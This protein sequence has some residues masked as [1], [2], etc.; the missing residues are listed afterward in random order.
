MGATYR[1]AC[2]DLNADI[3]MIEVTA[4]LAK[5]KD[6]GASLDNVPPVVM[7]AHAD[8]MECEVIGALTQQFNEVFRTG[9]VP[10]EWQQHRMLL[11]HKGHGANPSA[12][13][14]YRAIGIGCC[15][16]KMLSL[17]MEERLNT[18][19]TAT[20]SLS[21]NQMGFKRRSGTR[22]ATLALSEIIKEA[23]RKGPVL[24]AFID[25]RAAYDSVIREVLYAKMLKM[26]I[27]GRFLTTV[28][29]LYHSMEAELEVGG[30]MIGKVRME[31]G[32]AQG[33]PLSPVL[34][35]IYINSCI[36]ELEKLAQKRADESDG[37]PYGLY[38]P[39]ADGDVFRNGTG[40]IVKNDRIASVW[41]ADDS[42]VLETEGS[43][44]QWLVDTL[45][46]L[47]RLIGLMMNGRKTKY[48]ITMGLK[49]K[50]APLL[51][52]G[53]KVQGKLVE[54]VT[55]FP[56]LGTMLNSR[57]NWEGAW[58]TAAQR[59]GRAYHDAVAGG[60]FFHAGSLALMVT[61]ARAKIWS[62]FDSIMALTGAGGTLS[63]AFCNKADDNITKVLKSIVGYARCTQELL[64]IESGIWDTRTRADMLVMRFFTKI[65][66][67]DHDSLIWR[68]V[69]MS[70]QKLSTEVRGK[71][72]TKWNFSNYV[73]RQS[74]AQQVLAAAERLDIPMDAVVNMTP[75]MLLVLQEGRLIGGVMVWEEVFAP[76]D[77]VPMWDCA[78]RLLVRGLPDGHLCVVDVDYWLVREEHVGKGPVLRQM[79]EPLRLANFAAIR[80]K[81]NLRRRKLVKEFVVEQQRHG[82]SNPKSW[83]SITGYSSFMPPYWHIFDVKA[84]R[85]TVRTRLH[86]ACNEG[87]L[88]V[89]PITTKQCGEVQG[90]VVDRIDGSNRRACYLCEEVNGQEGIFMPESLYH[91]LISCPNGRMEALRMK[92]KG[93]LQAL[94]AIEDGLRDHP[95]PE[96]S[97]S[98][99][100]S[101]LLLCTTSESF[102]AEQ[103]RSERLQAALSA[104]EIRDQPPRIDRDGVVAAVNWLTPLVDAWMDRLRQYHN[105]GE[106]AALPGAKV[107]AM[108]CAHIRGVFREH[109]KALE[110]NVDYCCR[111]RDPPQRPKS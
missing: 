7:Q 95:V 74:W 47:L 32:L 15:D 46:E 33:S 21:H 99:M 108:V 83:A 94:C 59:A 52:V 63:S 12:L 24:T 53:L 37:V 19:L 105:V 42:A 39:S 98:V 17:I 18:F 2:Q 11:V 88:R 90:I 60:S 38:V 4:M 3:T 58:N 8:H 80:R 111:S 44:L 50:H 102:P 9:V 104:T 103:R 101:L 35:N 56:H 96:L 82:N 97:Q 25:V 55:E 78:V 91:M 68:V 85:L 69:R 100:W 71:P 73:H 14:S 81:A 57:G 30:A 66:S 29:G 65:C 110:D 31:V 79:S 26:G 61:S 109:R 87:A 41:F 107:V 54:V 13:D 77:F 67:S 92:F 20:N 70:M 34:F 16:L 49:S 75:G 1:V 36:S 106:T 62:Y 76:A 45:V 86:C 27:G 64:R 89:V 23:S 93:G 72:C 84:A 28:Q 40:D 5:M 48:M 6:V 10:E 43:R 22:E 51:D